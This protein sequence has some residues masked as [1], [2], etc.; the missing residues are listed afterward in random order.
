MPR[1]H[2]PRRVGYR[3]TDTIDALVQLRMDLPV[4][5][6]LVAAVSFGVCFSS[7]ACKLAFI[8]PPNPPKCL[9]KEA[10]NPSLE[11]PACGK[12]FLHTSCT[13]KK[14]RIISENCIPFCDA[15]RHEVCTKNKNGD[16]VCDCAK[17]FIRDQRSKL[18]SKLNRMC[19]DQ[20][21]L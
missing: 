14:A 5:V 9:G 6:I 19:F 17:G 8:V 11:P 18:C 20:T 12:K 1:V 15:R 2:L 7:R 21:P 4:I 16:L 3:L 10:L 13:A